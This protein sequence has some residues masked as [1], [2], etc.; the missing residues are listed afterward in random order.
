MQSFNS[1]KKQLLLGQY[2]FPAVSDIV[3]KIEGSLKNREN[4]GKL[5]I[6]LS[7]EE[8]RVLEKKI[9]SNPK[10]LCKILNAHV[11]Y[12]LMLIRPQIIEKK[13][14]KK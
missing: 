4:G 5:V 1:A 9:D 7:L 6:K 10:F 2:S 14:T 11:R 13:I 12:V 8:Y 3:R